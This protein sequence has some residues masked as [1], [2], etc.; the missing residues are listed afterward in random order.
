MLQCLREILK[1]DAALELRVSA[2]EADALVADAAANVDE[3]CLVGLRGPGTNLLLKREDG[4]PV[5]LAD[6]LHDL[7]ELGKVLGL[8]GEPGEKGQLRMECFLQRR[9][10]V[11]SHV[12]VLRLSQMVREGLK[13]RADKVKASTDA[14]D[15]VM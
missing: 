4:E 12:L 15:L 11:F 13:G 5:A 8:I 1:H 2:S 7:L 3:Q 6:D 9:L 10:A 14:E